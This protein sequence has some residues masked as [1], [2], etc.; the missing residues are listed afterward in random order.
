MHDIEH[1]TVDTQKHD[2]LSHSASEG[3]GNISDIVSTN[4]L[5]IWTEQKEGPKVSMLNE[6]YIIS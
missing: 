4:G 1:P 2:Q 5:Q 6:S 3:G